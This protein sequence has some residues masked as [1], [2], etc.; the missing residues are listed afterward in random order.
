M[1]RKRRRKNP[2]IPL[3]MAV[4]GGAAAYY[5]LCYKPKMQVTSTQVTTTGPAPAAGLGSYGTLSHTGYGSLQ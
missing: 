5:Y 3:W 1:P 2:G 4:A